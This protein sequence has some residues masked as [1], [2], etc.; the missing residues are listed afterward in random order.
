MTGMEIFEIALDICGL[1]KSNS[2]IPQ[3]VADLQQ[4]A[5]SLLN[6][7]LGEIS[8]LDSRIKKSEHK[9]LRIKSLDDEVLCSDI[10]AGSVI[11]YGVARLMMAGEDDAFAADITRLYLDAQQQALTFGKAK[12]HSITE[13][14]G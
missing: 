6:I 13:V 14:Y 7:T 10:L 3:D 11:P 4:R 9:V 1:R 8:I 12:T 2:E 5:V